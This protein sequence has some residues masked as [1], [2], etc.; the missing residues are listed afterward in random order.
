VTRYTGGIT[1]GADLSG[2]P[3]VDLPRLEAALR[4]VLD[5][6]AQFAKALWYQRAQDLGIR[7]SGAYLAGIQDAQIR[8]VEETGS[9][10][11][12]EVVFEITNTAPHA[13][14]VEDGHPAFHLPDKINWNAG[15]GRIKRTAEGT[16][17]LHIP[18]RHAAF[19]DGSSR[20][21]SGLTVSTLRRMM[22]A[23]VYAAAKRL[24]YTT[25]TSGPRFRAG[26]GGGQQFVAAGSY[27]RSGDRARY[28][29]PTPGPRLVAGAETAERWRSSRT[30][31]GRSAEGARLTN[32]AWATARYQ[33]LFKAG[34][35]GHASYMTVRTL[36]PQSAGWSIPA[37]LGHGVARQVAYMLNSGGP[38]GQR[39]QDLL[40][41]TARNALQGG[42]P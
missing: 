12:M 13:A 34:T 33:G 6:A 35:K 37:Q 3:D 28:E 38:A 40:V 27:T 21:S 17:Y 24:S 5:T 25:Q 2:L 1:L 30:V 15:D 16:P 18:F 22:P 41:Q 7:D 36:T 11:E 9:S 31:Q 23:E 8:V 4:A 42:Q 19:A 32:P 14:I 20:V 39:F 29:D 26:A 10:G